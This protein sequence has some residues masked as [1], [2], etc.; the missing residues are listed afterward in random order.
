MSRA[1][2]LRLLAALCTLAGVMLALL[3]VLLSIFAWGEL[4]MNGPWLIAILICG[5]GGALALAS[6]FADQQEQARHDD[7]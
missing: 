5:V 6:M 4:R 3:W 1:Q 2:K 7:A